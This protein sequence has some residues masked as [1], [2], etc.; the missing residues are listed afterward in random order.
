MK[1]LLS[2]ILF[3]SIHLTLIGQPFPF[4]NVFITEVMYNTPGNS[5]SLDFIELTVFPPST[6]QSTFYGFS[7]TSGIE[8][9]FPTGSP[10]ASVG[11]II[12]I[13]KDS[14]AFENTF[15]VEAYQWQ[16][17]SL[18]NIEDSIMLPHEVYPVYSFVSYKSYAPWPEQAN[19]NGASIVLCNPV[20]NGNHLDWEASQNNTGILVNG[21]SIYA[22]P[23]QVSECMTVGLQEQKNSDSVSIYPNP[24]KS[25][26]TIQSKTPLTQVSLTDLT[27]HRLVAFSSQSQNWQMDV[28][29]FGSGIYLVEAITEDGRRSVQ[30]VVVE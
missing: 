10:V 23:G 13:A 6:G 30:K 12:I 5:D 27:G 3:L 7:F 25:N 20:H 21:V 28:S 16:S 17:G 2:A 1:H 29:S 14:A 22:D 19:G 4:P 15:G 18:D 8:Y 9:E 11:S 26:L 24:A